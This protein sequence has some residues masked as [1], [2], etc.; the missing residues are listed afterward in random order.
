M[1]DFLST[2][3]Y[4]ERRQERVSNAIKDLKALQDDELLSSAE[5]NTGI[6]NAIES[7]EFI[8]NDLQEKYNRVKELFYEESELIASCY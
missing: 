1:V 8:F 7:L 6:A 5:L 3:E 4:I 2:L